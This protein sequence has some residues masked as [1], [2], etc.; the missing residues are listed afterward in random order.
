MLRRRRGDCAYRNL[1]P[2]AQRRRRAFQGALTLPRQLAS[3]CGAGVVRQTKP[4]RHCASIPDYL[5]SADP[6]LRP[7]TPRAAGGEGAAVKPQKVRRC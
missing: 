3:R 6:S 5:A 1:K 7:G 4:L 2:P